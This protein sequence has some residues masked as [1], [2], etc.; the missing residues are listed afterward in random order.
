VLI[1]A[2]LQCVAQTVFYFFAHNLIMALIVEFFKIAILLAI[3]FFFQSSAVRMIGW[4]SPSRRY[5]MIPVLILLT[6]LFG[7]LLIWEYFYNSDECRDVPAFI[8]S[9]FHVILSI[10]FAA[11]SCLL[12][13]LLQ[14]GKQTTVTSSE[15]KARH[16]KPMATLA[17]VFCFSASINTASRIYLFASTVN[18]EVLCASVL[19]IEDPLWVWFATFFRIIDLYLPVWSLMWYFIY[20]VKK[21]SRRTTPEDVYQFEDHD[22]DRS[23]D[24]GAF[25]SQKYNQQPFAANSPYKT[26]RSAI[27]HSDDDDEDPGLFTDYSGEEP[28]ASV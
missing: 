7:G 26:Y 4:K 24:S 5:L 16:K 22:S 14:S 3:C 2:F 27:N 15:Y 18:S 17:C 12:V 13:F 1:W 6:G 10:L 11:V 23:S 21:H 20:T 28:R 19:N 9:I 8:F 25:S